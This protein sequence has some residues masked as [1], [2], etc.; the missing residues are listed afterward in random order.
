MSRPSSGNLALAALPSLTLLGCV[1]VLASI[2][3][4]FEEPNTRMLLVSALLLLA[5]PAGMALHLAFT[6]LPCV[7]VRMV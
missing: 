5:A 2:M 1:G 3:M 6:G 7:S 4:A